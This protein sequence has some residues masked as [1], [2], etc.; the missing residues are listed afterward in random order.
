MN[1]FDLDVG[2]SVFHF[3]ALRKTSSI[4]DMETLPT[5]MDDIP[6]FNLA[7]GFLGS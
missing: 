1:L 2:R 3:Y 4:D 7:S 5:Y 6:A